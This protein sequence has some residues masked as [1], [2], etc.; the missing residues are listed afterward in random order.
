MD[1]AGRVIGQASSGAEIMP[2]GED[3]IPRLSDIELQELVGPVALYPDDLLAVVLPASAYPLQV[4]A[5]ARFLDARED[6]PSLEPNPDWDDSIVALLNYPE[7]VELLNRDLDWTYRLGE[8]VVAQQA[9]VVAAVEGFRDRAYAAGNLRSDEYQTIERSDDV[10]S[11][12]PV[13]DDAIYVPYYEPERVVVYQPRPVYY[14]YPRPCPVYY[15]PYSSSYRFDRGFFW[16]VT[17]A[18][19]I[20]WRSDSVHVYHHSYR[21]HPYY[22]RYYRDN[23]WYRRP[24]I[25]IHNTTYVT[26]RTTHVNVSRSIHIDRGDRWHARADRRERLIREG[27][28]DRSRARNSR[29]VSTRN[30][31]TR[32]V[33]TRDVRSTR[34]TSERDSNRSRT[35]TRETI[36]F[37]DRSIEADRRTADR[38]RAQTQTRKSPN[39]ASSSQPERRY[40]TPKTDTRVPIT[41][42]N[43]QRRQ[44]PTRSTRQDPART[45]RQAPTRS[46]RQEPARRETTRAPRQER[47]APARQSRSEAPRREQKERERTKRRR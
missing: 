11:I 37:R 33:A 5:A 28:T 4:A 41:R 30:V 6:D 36:R 3:D 7:V 16:G 35:S 15:Y 44:A 19:A 22:G 12:T 25:N 42:S 21:G 38:S 17:T 13:A 23:W 14:Y 26:N 34:T 47:A 32:S 18:F 39:R 46:T 1:D 40:V 9:D 31:N 27:Y 24:S 8:A 20:G 43:D 2:L 45:V 10:I 29:N